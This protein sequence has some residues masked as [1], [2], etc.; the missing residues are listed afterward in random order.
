M[1]KYRCPCGVEHE[2]DR[3]HGM[4]NRL[5]KFVEVEDH[6][7][8]LM[9]IGTNDVVQARR[10]LPLYADVA[11]DYAFAS[12]VLY[13]DVHAVWLAVEPFAAWDGATAYDGTALPR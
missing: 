4:S 9:F 1:K 12:H 3:K 8:G 13:N 11:E 10:L 5:D 2:L 7:N 6:G